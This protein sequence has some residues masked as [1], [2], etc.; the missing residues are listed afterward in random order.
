MPARNSIKQYLEGGYYHVYNRGV[1]KRNIFLDQ[2]DYAVFLSYLREYLTP[3]NHLELYQKISER[4]I[5]PLEKDKYIKQLNR[6]NFFE[7]VQLLA[8]SLLPNHFHFLLKQKNATS[9]DKFM[10]S[11]GTRYTMYFNKKYERVGRLYQDVYKAVLVLTDE[12]LLHLSRYIHRQ[13]IFLQGDPLQ[14]LQK[15]HSSYPEYIASRNTPWISRNEIL[16][17]F[18]KEMP[19]LTYES[20][21]KQQDDFNQIA[22]LILESTGR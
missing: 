5:S 3:K 15:T 2:Q 22:G 11:I 17:F 9:M 6:N 4:D 18:S 7:E 8:Y 21:V 14:N 12:Q 19:A 20:F 1:E 13:A 16:S 10:N